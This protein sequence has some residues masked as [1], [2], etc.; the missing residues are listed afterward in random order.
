MNELTLKIVHD[1]MVPDCDKCY[2][3][4][5]HLYGCEQLCYNNGVSHFELKEE[6]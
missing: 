1:G 4:E 5:F 6:K 2:Y 3:N